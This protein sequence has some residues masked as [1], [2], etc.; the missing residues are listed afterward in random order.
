MTREHS[1][2]RYFVFKQAWVGESY[3]DSRQWLET[4]CIVQTL[5][6]IYI[7]KYIYMCVCIYIYS[8]VLTE[9]INKVHNY[10]YN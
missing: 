3:P 10:T 2:L 7:Y 6:C 1:Y 5:N 9:Q 8:V 4:D